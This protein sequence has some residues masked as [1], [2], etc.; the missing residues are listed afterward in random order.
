MLMKESE[1][2]GLLVVGYIAATF[3]MVLQGNSFKSKEKEFD[4]VRKEF[5]EEKQHYFHGE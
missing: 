3:D 1:L 2:K 4:T 5:R